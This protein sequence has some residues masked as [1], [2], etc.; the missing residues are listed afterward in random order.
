[1]DVARA[2]WKRTAC[3][4]ALALVTPIGNCGAAEAPGAPAPP[5][6]LRS[7]REIASSYPCAML[8]LLH[9][10]SD[11]KVAGDG[12]LYIEQIPSREN[13]QGIVD[14]LAAGDSGGLAAALRNNPYSTDDYLLRIDWKTAVGGNANTLVFEAELIDRSGASLAPRHLLEADVTVALSTSGVRLA[15]DRSADDSRAAQRKGLPASTAVL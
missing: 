12:T 11:P 4:L 6:Y 9:I 13:V 2:Q 10:I 15:A 3:I 1:M 8:A 14:E 5:A 7:I